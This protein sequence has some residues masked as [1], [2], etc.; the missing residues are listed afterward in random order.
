MARLSE[1]AFAVLAT[2]AETKKTFGITVDEI[3]PHQYKFVWAFKIDKARAHREGYDQ[4]TVTGSVEID[5]DFPGCPYCGTKLTHLCSGC[6]RIV[7]HQP[8]DRI[9]VCP[10]CGSLG[11][12]VQVDEVSLK[13]GGY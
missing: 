9:V 1:K 8:D 5:D 6:G 7:C 13:G 3:G 4:R 10:E 11:E 2:C 12:L